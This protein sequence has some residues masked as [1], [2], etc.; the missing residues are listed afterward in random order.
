MT[1]LETHSIL[2]FSIAILSIKALSIKTLSFTTHIVTSL[3][4]TAHSVQHNCNKPIENSTECT[5][6]TV[7]NS[8]ECCNV[9]TGSKD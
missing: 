3:S 1:Q 7:C 6:Y 5:L 2:A 8:A 4:L 9:V